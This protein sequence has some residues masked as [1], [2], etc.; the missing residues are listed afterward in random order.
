VNLL[1]CS[2]ATT[3]TDQ[4]GSTQSRGLNSARRIDA[5]LDDIGALR[6]QAVKGVM[7]AHDVSVVGLLWVRRENSKIEGREIVC[8]RE[9]LPLTC[10][11]APSWSQTPTTG[12]MSANDG[13]KSIIVREI[14][15]I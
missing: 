7:C 4:V 6:E 11:P 14:Y 3:A 15:G 9:A 5:L 12:A 2:S 10:D 8:R 13:V 1:I